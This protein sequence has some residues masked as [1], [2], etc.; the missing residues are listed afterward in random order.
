[1]KRLKVFSWILFI[2]LAIV[3]ALNRQ[4]IIDFSRGLLYKPTPEM[5]QIR[6]DLDLTSHGEIIFNASHPEL[7]TKDDFNEKCRDDET[8]AIL[9]C[10]RE[11]NIYVY[12]I[13]DEKLDGIL[14]LTTAHELLHA[15][16]ERMSIS[17]K[18]DLKELLEN[19]YVENKVILEKE[20]G[21]YETVEQ[22][23][24]IYVRV[25]TEVKELPDALEKHYAT[26]FV[27]QDKIV[28]YY[29]KYIKIF[30][31]IE[32]EFKKIEYEMTELDTQIDTKTDDYEKELSVLNA[33]IE[34]FNNCAET[35]GCFNSDYEFSVRRG[36]LVERQ[37]VLQALYDELDRLINQYNLDVD[38]FND[39]VIRSEDLQNII[40]SYERVKDL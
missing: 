37:T 33:E 20:V 35:P 8:A 9:G 23:E 13:T 29:N 21:S 30:R 2:G 3:I 4:V 19:V 31:E 38:K 1:M 26:I 40:N 12:N 25:G 5:E 39:N 11:Q 16:Y 6:T 17:E 34:E 14:E 36:E 15:V 28:D 10:Y 22:L 7:N 32:D 24:E 27:D 18:D